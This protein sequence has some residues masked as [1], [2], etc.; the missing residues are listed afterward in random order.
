MAQ[1]LISGGFKESQ[2]QSENNKA[3]TNP[4]GHLR[5]LCVQSDGLGLGH[6]GVCTAGNGTGQT[7]TFSGLEKHNDDKEKAGHKLKNSDGE[8]HNVIQSFQW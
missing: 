2:S 8:R 1:G 3:Q 7:G 5:K 6:E 4:L